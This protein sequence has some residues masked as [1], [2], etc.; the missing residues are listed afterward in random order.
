MKTENN[1]AASAE[2]V[3]ENF[4]KSVKWMQDANQKL[5]EQQKQQIKQLTDMLTNNSVNT[6]Q[7]S[8]FTSF[9]N[10]DNPFA[11]STKSFTELYKKNTKAITDMFT[12]ALKPVMDVTKM[13]NFT[14]KDVVT[15]N[16]TQQF[17]ELKSKIEDLTLLNQT[18]FDKLLK[19]YNSTVKSFSP[20]T[21]DFKNEVEKTMEAYKETFQNI[22]E[23]YTAFF[24]PSTEPVTLV[25]NNLNEQLKTTFKDNVKF[26]TELANKNTPTNNNSVDV[27][28]EVLKTTS[29]NKK[30]STASLN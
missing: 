17:D 24:T 22:Q 23:S 27:D 6:D 8:N 16:A 25:A 3:K 20:L 26:W 29:K 4:D 7:F 11:A 5:V 18:N 15:K 19:Q 14:D 30:Q 2:T 13:T 21:E 1:F 12:T 9:N 10:F 28:A